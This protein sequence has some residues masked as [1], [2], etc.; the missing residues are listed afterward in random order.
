MNPTLK[1][2]LVVVGIGLAG[3]IAY[4]ASGALT[5]DVKVA[6]GIAASGISVWILAVLFL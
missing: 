2:G 5:T 3:V 6:G 4:Q 1:T